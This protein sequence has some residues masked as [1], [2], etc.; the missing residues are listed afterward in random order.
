M[1]KPSPTPDNTPHIVLEPPDE[2]MAHEVMEY[3]S[4]YPYHTTGQWTDPRSGGLDTPYGAAVI[5]NGIQWNDNGTVWDI[6]MMRETY[7]GEDD[8]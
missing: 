4:A 2:S 7:C 1:P 8:E 3:Q 5:T 6:S